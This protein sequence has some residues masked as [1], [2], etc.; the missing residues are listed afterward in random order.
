M[1]SPVCSR[2]W[3]S[4]SCSGAPSDDKNPPDKNAKAVSKAPDK[5]AD[6][7]GWVLP[8]NGPARR[9]KRAGHVCPDKEVEADD[10]AAIEN[11]E[12]VIKALAALAKAFNARDPE[13]I[14]ELFTPKG[15]FI[16]ADDNVF[17]SHAAIA[18]E[19]KVLFE[20]NPKN[21]IEFGAEEIRE[22]SP[23]IL[24]VDCVA[25]FSGDDESDPDD[26]D[27]SALLV[28]QADG[29]WLLAS[30]RSEGEGNLRTPHARLKQ[31][32]WLIGEWVDE[33]GDSTMHTSTRWSE[34]GQFIMTTFAIHVAGRKVM[35]G[36]QRI[37][38]D[39]S[40]DKFRSWVFDSE[41]GHAEGIWTEIDD[42]W[43]V[44]V[45]GVRPDGDACSATNTYEPQGA[46]AYLFSVTDR[47]VG[48]ETESDFF[49]TSS[50]RNRLSRRRLR[51]RTSSLPVRSL[52]VSHRP[53]SSLPPSSRRAS[54]RSPSERHHFIAMAFPGSRIMKRCMKLMLVLFIV[55]CAVGG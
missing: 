46:E 7:A 16:D 17:D 28:K 9:R 20:I 25:A 31:L 15:E 21:T 45:A 39:G 51:L 40:L 35:S 37:G 43:V 12:T 19:F 26:I 4:S 53:P 50:S 10:P 32:E 48:N 24:S 49:G 3:F 11:A 47:I 44:N 2:C 54:S 30:V 6:A 42:A 29:K 27:F 13:A 38:W 55:G 41:G 34:D 36:T 18:G 22:I 8:D 14:S 23:G 5:N 1:Q 33:S 52:R